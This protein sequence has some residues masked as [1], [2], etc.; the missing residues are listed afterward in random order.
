MNRTNG[1]RSVLSYVLALI[2]VCQSAVPAWAQTP[3]ATATPTPTPVSVD[4]SR[5]NANQST[6]HAIS[7]RAQ[8]LGEKFKVASQKDPNL[9]TDARIKFNKLKKAIEESSASEID[10][11]QKDK[12]LTAEQKESEIQN[13]KAKEE[14]AILAQKEKFAQEIGFD[15]FFQTQQ[16]GITDPAQ[17]TIQ[18]RGSES[19][20]NSEFNPLTYVEYIIILVAG[21]LG[22]VILRGCFPEGCPSVSHYIF[23]ISLAVY[24]LGEVLYFFMYK[25]ASEKKL[26]LDKDKNFDQQLQSMKK[27]KQ[28]SEEAAKAAKLKSIILSVASTGMWAAMVAAIVEFNVY[29]GLCTS[30]VASAVGC[31]CAARDLS[32]EAV[33][34]AAATQGAVDDFWQKKRNETFSERL[35]RLSHLE[36]DIDYKR[37]FGLL[38]N[39]LVKADSKIY[40]TQIRQAPAR[41]AFVLFSEW[42]SFKNGGTLSYDLNFWRAIQRQELA[43]LF[44]DSESSLRGQALATFMDFEQEVRKDYFLENLIST[45]HADQGGKIGLAASLGLGAVL[46]AVFFLVQK[47]VIG[48]IL[49]TFQNAVTRSVFFGVFA[50]LASATSGMAVVASDDLQEHADKYGKVE[51]ELQGLKEREGQ[52]DQEIG[53]PDGAALITKA[54][55]SYDSKFA[56][57]NM[58]YDDLAQSC[59]RMGKGPGFEQDSACNCKKNDQCAKAVA[60]NAKVAAFKDFSNTMGS[61]QLAAD[62]NAQLL[63]NLGQGN[64]NAAGASGE[65]TGRLA[66]ALRKKASELQA[67]VDKTALNGKPSLNQQMNDLRGKLT[68]DVQKIVKAQNVDLAKEFGGRL[69]APAEENKAESADTVQDTE[70]NPVTQTPVLNSNAFGSAGSGVIPQNLD[71][72]ETPIAAVE[73]TPAAGLEAYEMN[74]QSDVTQD[75]G[76]S[77][78]Q[79]LSVRYIKTA[80][81]S[82][83]EEIGTTPTTPPMRV[84][85]SQVPQEAPATEVIA[86]KDPQGQKAD[87]LGVEEAL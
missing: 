87:S 75:P 3:K 85:A 50:G 11:V 43:T 80:M 31:K 7:P 1:L 9:E 84:P 40:Q 45:A 21:F 16:L 5:L 34:Q 52:I 48:E 82:L 8:E 73:E 20:D 46:A 68:N 56:A 54:A 10:K 49:L 70:T 32:C 38:Q 69:G 79:V 27:A 23:G 22:P 63:G 76:V 44:E 39:E 15:N 28:V 86:P 36:H 71:A 81:P 78:W 72:M 41:E 51:K 25:S 19:V 4:R 17:D 64:F 26:A 55:S 57:K 12:N 47:K 60:P 6:E 66:M 37:T 14:R 59:F 62:K 30:I 65:G 35:F 2:M 29:T 83:L 13:I 58:V 33:A 77:I 61:V 42:M 67:Y 18:K 53:K 74:A 24:F